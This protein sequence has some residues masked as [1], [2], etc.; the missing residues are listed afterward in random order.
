MAESF[1]R[2]ARGPHSNPAP[3]ATGPKGVK[4]SGTLRT[5]KE[6]I[7][8]WIKSTQPG[9]PATEMGGPLESRPIQNQYISI[10]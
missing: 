7:C 8:R 3:W 5:N 9:R 1:H 6:Q 2:E 4:G 10:A